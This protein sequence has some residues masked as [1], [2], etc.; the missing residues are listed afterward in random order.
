M[1]RIAF[2]LALAAASTAVAVAQNH[3]P[4]LAASFKQDYLNQ[5]NDAEKKFV[6]L[7]EAMPSDKYSWRPGLG[8]RSVSEVFMHVAGANYAF[9]MR[10]G[11]QPP[12]GG[13]PR[14]LE[15]AVT[16]KSQVVD[17]L[18]ASFA[19]VRNYVEGLSD[20]DLA[21]ETKFF[22]GK[23]ASYQDILFFMANHMHEHL[24]Q[25][26]AYARTNGVVPPWSQKKS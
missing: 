24:G 20:A 12:A 1:T 11:A 17:A 9:A 18:K 14:N 7:A 4:D 3:A 16:Q 5:L 26:I 19:Y 13:A 21:K 10:V 6:S 8:V 2:V 25:A 23:M 22:G 15:K